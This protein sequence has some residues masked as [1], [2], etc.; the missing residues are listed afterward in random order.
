MHKLVPEIFPVW[1]AYQ[2]NHHPWVVGMQP[3]NPILL[4]DILSEEVRGVAFTQG[5]SGFFFFDPRL[6]DETLLSAGIS[7]TLYQGDEE[8]RRWVSPVPK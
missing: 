7:W 6:A 3:T 8:G 2:H 4:A 1:L 5:Q